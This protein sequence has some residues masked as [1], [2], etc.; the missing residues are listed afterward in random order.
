MI[1]D[2]LDTFFN[3]KYI[4]MD[5]GSAGKSVVQHLTLDPLYARKQYKERLIPIQFGSFIAIGRDLD[6]KETKV[7]AKQFSMQLLQAKTNNHDIIYSWS[8]DAMINELERTTYSRT[9]SGDLVFKTV[10]HQGSSRT[11][12]DHNVSAL[13]CFVLAHYLTEEIDDYLWNRNVKLYQP[14]WY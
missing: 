11:V 8:D 4:G 10:S 14:R 2:R 13:L 5:E 3:P 12:G 9:P 6:G 1:I 7:R